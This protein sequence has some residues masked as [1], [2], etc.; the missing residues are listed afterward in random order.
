[1]A[2]RTIRHIVQL[3][4]Y[5][6]TETAEPSSN[7]TIEKTA[8]I[9]FDRTAISSDALITLSVGNIFSLFDER[10]ERITE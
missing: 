4:H 1:M 2:Y 9:P 5:T 7:L 10:A 3:E 6:K 8:I